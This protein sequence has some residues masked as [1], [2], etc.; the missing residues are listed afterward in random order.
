MLT[1]SIKG[2]LT[3]CE[4]SRT[5]TSS[6]WGVIDSAFYFTLRCRVDSLLSVRAE[7]K[8]AYRKRIHSSVPFQTIDSIPSLSCHK[9]KIVNS[10]LNYISILN[11]MFEFPCI[12][13]IYYIK[14][15]Q[16]A[17]L[18]VLFISNCKI[19]LHHQEY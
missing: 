4:T 15:Q 5:G 14:N 16:D 10:Q 8:F 17:T 1:G 3:L 9:A 18:A 11:F 13:R 12:L 6:S 19:T 7:K 2:S